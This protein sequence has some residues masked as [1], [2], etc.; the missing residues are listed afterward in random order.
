V[1]KIVKEIID[2]M[3]CSAI[4]FFVEES[5]DED[6]EIIED[7]YDLWYNYEISE[8]PCKYLKEKILKIFGVDDD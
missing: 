1:E 7:E 6:D 5:H 8:E 2:E 3:G 4:D